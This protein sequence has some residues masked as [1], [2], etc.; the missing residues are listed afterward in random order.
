[1][2]W[3]KSPEGQACSENAKNYLESGAGP[4]WGL[5]KWESGQ[6]AVKSRPHAC[7]KLPAEAQ[8]EP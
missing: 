4:L 3:E 5:L 2:M 7:E 1:M 8:R 6:A